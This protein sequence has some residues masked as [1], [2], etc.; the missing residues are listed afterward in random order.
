M[1]ANPCLPENA[2]TKSVIAPSTTPPQAYPVRSPEPRSLREEVPEER[3]VR[4]GELLRGNSA[5]RRFADT[6]CG[7]C[8][9]P[10]EDVHHE[11][12]NTEHDQPCVRT[13]HITDHQ[14]GSDGREHVDGM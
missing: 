14:V 4:S 12:L 1:M 9:D 5:G 8:H 10:E 6:P 13:V 11:H 7:E 3:A 2:R